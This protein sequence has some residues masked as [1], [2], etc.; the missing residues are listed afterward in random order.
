MYYR[1]SALDLIVYTRMLYGLIMFGVILE[2]LLV[3]WYGSLIMDAYDG[4]FYFICYLFLFFILN[5]KF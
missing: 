2:Y 5:F 4:G 1:G 3:A